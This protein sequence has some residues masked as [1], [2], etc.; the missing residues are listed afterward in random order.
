MYKLES[1]G[2]MPVSAQQDIT[3]EV[4]TRRM[5]TNT[6]SIILAICTLLNIPNIEILTKEEAVNV[7]ITR[8]QRLKKMR[9]RN[10]RQRLYTYRYVLEITFMLAKL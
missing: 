6:R 8:V 4:F 1:P 2:T 3:I 10:M 9:V 5:M 7:L